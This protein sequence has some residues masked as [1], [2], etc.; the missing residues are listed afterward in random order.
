MPKFI[1]PEKL[2]F[3]KKKRNHVFKIQKSNCYQKGVGAHLSKLEILYVESCL[4]SERL[5]DAWVWL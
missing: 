5:C 1:L 3:F 2:I 4:L